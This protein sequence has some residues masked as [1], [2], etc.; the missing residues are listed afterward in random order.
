MLGI[1]SASNSLGASGAAKPMK[2]ESPS[3]PQIGM[4]IESM[5][6]CQIVFTKSKTLQQVRRKSVH[7]L[8]SLDLGKSPP[9]LN[10]TGEQP[11][12]HEMKPEPCKKTIV[13]QHSHWSDV[14]EVPQ[15]PFTGN[16]CCTAATTK[17]W[18][19]ELKG[20]RNSKCVPLIYSDGQSLRTLK[21]N[22]KKK[23]ALRTWHETNT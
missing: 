21:K 20:C 9:T 16:R 18:K 6:A 12:N 11:A 23:I 2:P 22:P 4:A 15:N 13:W 19:A 7:R 5:M 10:D 1:F 3:S 17:R 8:S 14:E